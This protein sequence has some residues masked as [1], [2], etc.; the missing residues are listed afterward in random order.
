[1]LYFYKCT[2]TYHVLVSKKS[3]YHRPLD[4]E[5]GHVYMV[6]LIKSST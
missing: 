6:Y 3:I 1:M 5:M 4:L 2:L